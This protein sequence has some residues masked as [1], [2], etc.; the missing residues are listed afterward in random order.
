[1]V[2]KAIQAGVD[3]EVSVLKTLRMTHDFTDRNYDRHRKD[4]LASERLSKSPYVVDI[5]AYCSNS[6]LFE[7]GDAG[8]IDKRI[9]PYDK[10][11]KKHYVADLSSLEKI[12]LGEEITLCLRGVVHCI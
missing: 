12:D 9:W 6:A 1:L 11:K 3:E 5:Y 8:D 4:A 2:S 10:K 7:Y